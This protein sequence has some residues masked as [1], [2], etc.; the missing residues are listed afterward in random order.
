MTASLY[1]GAAWA[2]HLRGIV[3]NAGAP[4]ND[5]FRAHDHRTGAANC[6]ACQTRRRTCGHNDCP[7]CAP[8]E[9]GPP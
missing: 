1:G 5:T 3:A 6:P 9:T 7:I 2:K 8:V 4:A